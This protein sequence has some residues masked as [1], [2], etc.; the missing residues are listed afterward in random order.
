MPPGIGNIVVNEAAERFSYYGMRAILVAFMMRHM[1][2]AA[3]APDGMAEAEARQW[4]HIFAF[5]VYFFPLLGASIADA[6]L[7]KFFT[8]IAFSLVYCGGHLAL[9]LNE[10]R[11]GLLTGLVLIAVGSG[12]IKPCVSANVG[13]QFGHRNQAQLPRAFSYFYF[14]INTGAFASSLVTPALLAC[15]GPHP[16]FGVP[17]IL[18][19]LATLA[20]WCGRA[21][22]THVPPDRNRWLAQSCSAEGWR[23]IAR[24]LVVRPLCPRSLPGG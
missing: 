16:A 22:Y 14:A 8:I 17:G 24:L 9:A 23:T 20:F 21:K 12:G 2:T 5:A 3:G 13:D 4:Y 6:L 19:A 15:C 18:M 11:S 10:T 7:G 1:R